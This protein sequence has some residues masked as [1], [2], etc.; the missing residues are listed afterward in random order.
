VSE[1][2]YA[3]ISRSWIDEWL[4]SKLV[5]SA[6]NDLGLNERWAWRAVGLIKLLAT[7]HEWWR[8]LQPTEGGT[9]TAGGTLTAAEKKPSAGEAAYQLLVTLLSEAGTQAYLGVNR[10]QDILWYNK[11][12]FGD[13]L[14]WL[15]VAAVVDLT[16]PPANASQ[17]AAERILACHEVIKHL[18]KAGKASDFQVEKL[19]EAAKEG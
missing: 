18:Q 3:E 8:L 10:Y 19:L 11:E 1:K 14:W 4:L 16:A 9:P 12:A 17:P 15:F 5:A 2:D 13:L 6:L 7:H